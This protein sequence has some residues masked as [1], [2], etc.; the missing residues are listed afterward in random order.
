M[1]TKL[2]PERHLEILA[3]AGADLREQALIAGLDAPVATC[4]EWTVADLVG[5]LGA[6]HRWAVANLTGGEHDRAAALQEAASSDDLLA[7]FADGLDELVATLRNAPDDVEAMVFLRDAPPPRRFW[8]RRQAH[9]TLIHGVDVL[10]AALGRLPASGECA[11][12]PDI[13]VDGLDE[14]L[15][16]F[17]T[18]RRNSIQLPGIQCLTVTTTDT[19]ESWTLHLGA[20]GVTTVAGS[21]ESADAVLSGTAVALYLGLWNRG[22][23][24]DGP[25]EIL[26]GWR[27]QATI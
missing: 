14:L 4:P 21:D 11:V 13:A 17:L 10:A 15:F 19:G 26:A 2:R 16:G 20:D 3:R 8:A 5:H 6:V 7:W 18:R 12:P 24:F 23:E 25:A 9:E 22:D 1:P 27:E